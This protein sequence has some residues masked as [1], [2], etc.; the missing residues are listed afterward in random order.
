V[1]SGCIRLTNG[2]ISDLYSRVKV[3]TRVVVLSG[4][5]RPGAAPPTASRRGA[6]AAA[7]GGAPITSDA[8]AQKR[9]PPK[10]PEQEVSAPPTNT[11]RTES[12]AKPAR[13][14]GKAELADFEE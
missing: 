5:E 11:P 2:D 6:A 7:R 1:S 9:K 13:K 14:E 3:G 12:Q 10:E 8:A 4:K